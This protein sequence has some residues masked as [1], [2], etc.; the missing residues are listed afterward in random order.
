VV[1]HFVSYHLGMALVIA[2]RHQRL[3]SDFVVE[4]PEVKSDDLLVVYS[5]RPYLRK[6]SFSAR[7][8][9]AAVAPGRTAAMPA[10]R[11]SRARPFVRHPPR[12][13]H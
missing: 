6:T 3:P 4:S 5:P 12:W 7:A 9:S 10:L 8:T 1:G 2:P 11:A 13:R